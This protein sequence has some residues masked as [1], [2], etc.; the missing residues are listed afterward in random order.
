MEEPDAPIEARE[1][2]MRAI[3][4]TL[5]V[6]RLARSMCLGGIPG[7]RAFG[8]TRTV[9]MSGHDAYLGKLRLGVKY[10]GAVESIHLRVK[11]AQAAQ[12]AMRNTGVVT[13]VESEEQIASLHMWEQGDVSLHSEET[14][15]KRLA[16]RRSRR[17]V[18]QL[19]SFW[20]ACRVHRWGDEDAGHALVYTQA[21]PTLDKPP[22]VLLA[23]CA[24]R[25]ACS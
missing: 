10:V 12:A 14:M 18:E 16:L 8:F 17:V 25:A 7:S 3:R 5:M 1:R 2:W 6:G 23:P 13:E 22:A 9:A 21:A 24:P 4:T 20:D 15:R 19:Q 11:A